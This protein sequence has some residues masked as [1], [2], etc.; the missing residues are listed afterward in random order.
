[1]DI[2]VLKHIQDEIVEDNQWQQQQPPPS[3]IRSELERGKQCRNSIV[4]RY[5]STH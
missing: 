5:F 4:Q 1:M 2:S 3:S